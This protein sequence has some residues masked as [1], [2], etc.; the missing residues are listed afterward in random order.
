M[1][2]N[3]RTQTS[4]PAYEEQISGPGVGKGNLVVVLTA[5]IDVGDIRYTARRDPL[6]RLA[7][8]KHALKQ[9]L[10]DESV[11]KI[12]FC[13]NSGF[14]LTE[15]EKVCAGQSHGNKDVEILSFLGQDFPP[16]LGKGF[17]EMRIL[18]HVLE[19]SVLLKSA[20]YIMKVTGRLYVKNVRHII[21]GIKAHNVSAID[22]GFQNIEVSADVFC[23][24]RNYLTYTD[25]RLFCCTHRFLENCLLPLA[26][27]ADDSAGMNFERVLARAVHQGLAQGYIWAMLPV[28]PHIL[29][30][31]A[32]DNKRWNPS[33]PYWI[34]HEIFNRLK[35]AVIAR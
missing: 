16:P 3:W 28:T 27:I 21:D 9:W 12:I 18:S 8:Y 22:V 17:G 10:A 19:H 4:T 1:L 31:S 30:V 14:D 25:C 29:G 34:T 24:L 13:E 7:D 5:T 15:I 11:S 26:G 20:T 35:T 23:N 6:T 2:N 32:S 33:L